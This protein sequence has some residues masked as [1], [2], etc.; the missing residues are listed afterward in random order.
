[1][2]N[3]FDLNPILPFGAGIFC[4]IRRMGVKML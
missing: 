1:M 2:A 4:W 3:R